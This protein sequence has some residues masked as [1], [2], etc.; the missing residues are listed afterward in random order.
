MTIAP[1]IT[2][3]TPA[4]QVQTGNPAMSYQTLLKLM[5]PMAFLI[6]ILYYRP[7]FDSQFTNQLGYSNYN[8]FANTAGKMLITVPDTWQFN[9][10]MFCYLKDYDI[11][12]E[13]QGL[14][15]FTIMPREQIQLFFMG[16]VI[17]AANALNAISP[18]NFKSLEGEMGR[19]GFFKDYTEEI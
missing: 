16:K 3:G 4:L 15:N 6:D 14:L 17:Y 1:T 19:P 10:S 9:T 13:G 12:F 2:F 5:G 8:V 18:G 7:R 11:V